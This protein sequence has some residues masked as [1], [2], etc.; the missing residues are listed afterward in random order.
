MQ[1]SDLVVLEI[2][3][4][5]WG[6]QLQSDLQIVEQRVELW[7][8]IE[9]A[10][11]SIVVDERT[12]Q[13]TIKSFAEFDKREVWDTEESGLEIATNGLDDEDR[14]VQRRHRKRWWDGRTRNRFRKNLIGNLKNDWKIGFSFTQYG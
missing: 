13:S 8:I 7:G 11:D 10:V 2:I 6:R 4:W 3:A 5:H 9:R 14:K 1:E 12:V